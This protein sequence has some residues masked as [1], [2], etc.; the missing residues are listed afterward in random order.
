MSH[1]ARGGALRDVQRVTEAIPCVASVCQGMRGVEKKEKGTFSSLFV[2][3]GPTFAQ[4]NFLCKD[5][6]SF[7]IYDV[8]TAFELLVLT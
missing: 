7:T 4:K 2:A 1:I 5:H 3:L 8:V 6:F